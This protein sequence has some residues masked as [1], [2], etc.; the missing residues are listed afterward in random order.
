MEKLTA[1][2]QLKTETSR[3]IQARVQAARNCQ[4]KRFA[5]TRLTCNSEMTTRE[6]KEF[7]PLVPECL[8]LLLQ[9]V[10]QFQLSARSYY[11]MIKVART[12]ADL[13][14]EKTIGPNHI[15]EAL[16]YRPQESDFV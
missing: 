5:K 8:T 2:D 4:T 12:V 11:R 1:I 9:A 13:A 16:Q 3:Q 7:C 6:V 10:S 15:A 14:G